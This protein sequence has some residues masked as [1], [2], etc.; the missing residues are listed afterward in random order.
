[1]LNHANTTEKADGNMFH[2]MLKMLRSRNFR[3]LWIGEAVSLLG[4]QFTLIALPWLVLQLTGDALAMGTVLALAGVPRAIFILLG[5]A[6]TD[7]FSPRT[8]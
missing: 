5:G 3:L 8:T 7:R 4:D 2:E 1:M 6:L